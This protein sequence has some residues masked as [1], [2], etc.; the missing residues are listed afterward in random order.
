[1]DG[2]IVKSDIPFFH[3]GQ[4]SWTPA[5]EGVETFLGLLFIELSHA[6]KKVDKS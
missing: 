2:K 5:R 1:M 4:L 3:H 6:R